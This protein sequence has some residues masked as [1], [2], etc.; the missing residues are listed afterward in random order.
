MNGK[1][2]AVRGVHWVGKATSP[3]REKVGS[4]SLHGEKVLLRRIVGANA[5]LEM[6]AFV[7][8]PVLIACLSRAAL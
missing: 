7:L 8:G 6:V 1:E 3:S 2:C 5:V 4:I